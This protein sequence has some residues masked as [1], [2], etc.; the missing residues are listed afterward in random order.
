MDLANCL[1]DDVK[2]NFCQL[3]NFI[4]TPTV[5]ITPH[6]ITQVL[7]SGGK[8]INIDL[9]YGTIE[10][11]QRLIRHINSA[12]EN[13]K[14]ESKFDIPV[15]KLCT[16]RG[17]TPSTGRMRNC[18]EWSLC[19]GE[20][21]VLTTCKPYQFCSTN[22][23]CFVSNFNRVIAQLK[24]GDIIQIGSEVVLNVAKITSN[25][26]IT[27][28]VR[29]GGKLESYQRLTLSCVVQDSLELEPSVEEL[30]DCEFIKQNE[31]DFVIAPSVCRPEYF[32]T[33]SKQLA[34][35]SI[36]MIA[37]VDEKVVDN[38][39]IDRIVEHFYGVYVNE[40]T[41]DYVIRKAR[42]TK[43]LIIA[44]LSSEDCFGARTLEIFT[45]SDSL[46]VEATGCTCDVNEIS[47]RLLKELRNLNMT[48]TGNNIADSETN[49]MLRNQ[50]AKAIVC[51]NQ[52]E[53][54]SISI[55]SSRPPCPIIQITKS[56][57]IAK[58]LQLWKNVIAI[59]YESEWKTEQTQRE[60]M[61]QIVKMYGESVMLF[62]DEDQF[63]C[64]DQM[65]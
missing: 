29:E 5:E 48:T 41:D 60:E 1:N 49:E 47:E 37:D 3:P 34:G 12:L 36:K 26:Y 10:D 32:H 31:F 6:E 25:S 22:Q 58:R 27:C 43:K 13:Y 24:P 63:T 14:N 35:C 21:I 61:M 19:R 65:H 55:A 20:E 16:I 15:P 11:N 28:C 17:R 57:S 62:K 51:V 50:A 42:E 23:V 59:V 39:V 52:T 18:C 7:R 54:N 56:P 64:M 53:Q 38:A 33:L 30:E 40:V 2:T 44:K 9:V 4:F 45:N 46:L 8:A